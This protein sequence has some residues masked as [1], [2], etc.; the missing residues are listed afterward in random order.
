MLVKEMFHFPPLFFSKELQL[1][2]KCLFLFFTLVN[3][4]FYNVCFVSV[5]IVICKPIGK[6]F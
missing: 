5:L 6:R 4:Q 3:C 1:E 2:E